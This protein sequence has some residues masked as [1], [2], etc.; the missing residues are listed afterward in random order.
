MTDKTPF[1]DED[2]ASLVRAAGP[3]EK[4]RAESLERM[5]QELRPLW[6]E[7]QASASPSRPRFRLF[8]AAAM[9][10][11][12]IAAVFVTRSALREPPVPF[13]TVA[14]HDG[15][16]SVWGP[17]GSE[18]AEVLALGSTL[19]T[20]QSIA[21]GTRSRIA[22]LAI[23]GHSVRLDRDSRLVLVS[24][25]EIR[26]EQGAVYLDSGPDSSPE[27][28]I[29]VLTEFG[30]VT[31]IG[32]QFEVRVAADSVRVRVREGEVSVGSRRTGHRAVSGEEL[33]VSKS[34]VVRHAID[35]YSGIFDWVGAIAPVRPTH[36]SP[37]P[38]FLEWAARENGLALEYSDPSAAEWAAG[39]K[40]TGDLE[41]LSPRQALD[42]V[43]PAVELSYRIEDGQL[44]ITRLESTSDRR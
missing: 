38:E 43:M 18:Q 28:A 36:K 9:L 29:S 22:L 20:G 12:A 44:I 31:E 27:S 13:A 10:A 25:R 14:R 4:M 24:E 26:L 30:T 7:Q 11:L 42:A 21:T 3:R 15:E 19:E 41:G 32:T 17:S 6:Q 35:L 2:V 39:I 5:Q 34:S 16:V 37:L 33:T 8:A 1:L 40:L 23:N